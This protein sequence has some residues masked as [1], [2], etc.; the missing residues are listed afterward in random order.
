MVAVEVVDGLEAVEVDEEDGQGAVVAPA[1]GQGLI[2]AVVE[3]GPVGQAG[4]GVVEGLVLAE[5]LQAGGEVAVLGQQGAVGQ[6]PPDG[7]DEGLGGHGLEEVAVHLA[8]GGHG[9]FERSLAG[10]EQDGQGG[11]ALLEGLG[12][13]QAVAV[14]EQ[15]V[16]DHQGGPVVGME[17]QGLFG[18]G[19]ADGGDP[20]RGQDGQEAGP[21]GDVVVHHQDGLRGRRQFPGESRPLESPGPPA[22]VTVSPAVPGQARPTVVAVAPPPPLAAFPHPVPPWRPSASDSASITPHARSQ[23]AKPSQYVAICARS[24]EDCATTNAHRE[25][26]KNTVGDGSE[27]EGKVYQSVT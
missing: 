11:V 5:P 9:T 4:Q 16:D 27:R 25:H 22:A 3:Q 14:R 26:R 8:D 13:L 17:G 21:G 24:G 23:S 1:G 18:A 19:R 20:G 6:G 7:V 2:D 12:Q 10:E 15:V